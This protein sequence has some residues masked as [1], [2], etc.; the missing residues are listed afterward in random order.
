MAADHE[1]SPTLLCQTPILLQEVPGFP[2]VLVIQTQFFIL[3]QEVPYWLSHLPPAQSNGFY[4][5]VFMHI[6]HYSLFL[7]P[8]HYHCLPPPFPDS[9]SF[10]FWATCVVTALFPPHS[11][12][13]P[14]VPYGSLPSTFT[15]CFLLNKIVFCPHWRTVYLWF[16]PQ[17]MS[18]LFLKSAPSHSRYLDSVEWK[19]SY[20][21]NVYSPAIGHRGVSVSKTEAGG[22]KKLTF[23][24]T[25]HDSCESKAIL[26]M[27][28][29]YIP[30]GMC[31]CVSGHS[32][33]VTRWT[34]SLYEVTKASLESAPRGLPYL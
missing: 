25:P 23:K 11:L 13:A 26:K 32:L 24:N 18:K 34:P 3:A 16:Y 7:S 28:F 31:N 17:K 5:D 33:I 4:G 1:S 21:D 8:Y 9:P 30:E 10:C 6:I 14:S 27:K 15:L 2:C 22:V 20:F 19:A 29:V 12:L